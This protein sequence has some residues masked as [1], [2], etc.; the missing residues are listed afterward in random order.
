M[1]T[2][3]FLVPSFRVFPVFFSLQRKRLRKTARDKPS[4][5]SLAITGSNPAPFQIRGPKSSWWRSSAGHGVFAARPGAMTPM[6]SG[7]IEGVALDS[8]STLDAMRE[9]LRG[10]IPVGATISAVISTAGPVAAPAST[11]M[12]ISR[13]IISAATGDRI[14][15]RLSWMMRLL[16]FRSLAGPRLRSIRIPTSA[17]HKQPQTKVFRTCTAGRCPTIPI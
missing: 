4:P 8:K 10:G 7:W 2:L 11:R 14:F 6:E 1:K 13:E 12:S 15:P 3:L 5:A 16:P 9:D 17:V